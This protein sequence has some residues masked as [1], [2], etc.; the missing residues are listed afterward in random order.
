MKLKVSP[1]MKARIY[2]WGAILLVVVL[3]KYYGGC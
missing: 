1:E 3:F 2:K